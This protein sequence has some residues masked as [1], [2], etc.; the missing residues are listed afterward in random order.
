MLMYAEVIRKRRSGGHA[1]VAC[2][3]TG[4]LLLLLLLLLLQRIA[5]ETTYADVF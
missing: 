5:S 1:T 4:L 2:M 3:H